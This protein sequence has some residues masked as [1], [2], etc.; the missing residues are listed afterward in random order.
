MIDY[1]DNISNL[2]HHPRDCRS[3]FQANFLSKR[4]QCPLT[5]SHITPFI[6][7]NNLLDPYTLL[8]SFSMWSQ[9]HSSVSIC[10]FFKTSLI[11][12]S[13]V[14]TLLLLITLTLSLTLK[15][16]VF[17]VH[18][19][20]LHFPSS[21]QSVLAFFDQM[22]KCFAVFLSFTSCSTFSLPSALLYP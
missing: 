12:L 13:P 20:H 1:G 10:A 15:I 16:I 8:L 11:Q 6:E 14:R 18:G 5:G 9:T 3:Q 2:D 21:I 4:N 19:L 17:E 22:L 7:K